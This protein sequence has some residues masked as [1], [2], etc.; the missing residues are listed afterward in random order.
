M[1]GVVEA[2]RR[3]IVKGMHVLKEVMLKKMQQIQDLVSNIDSYTNYEFETDSTGFMSMCTKSYNLVKDLFEQDPSLK[4]DLFFTEAY[5]QSQ[6][7]LRKGAKDE[8]SL[9]DK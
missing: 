6:Q 8:N 4:R 1:P 7:D 2:D 9:I 5:L 3:V